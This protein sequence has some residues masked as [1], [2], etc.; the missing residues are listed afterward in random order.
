[1]ELLC[2]VGSLA[3]EHNIIPVGGLITGV[4]IEI[5]KLFIKKP[6]LHWSALLWFLPSCVA[7]LLITFTLVRSLVRWLVLTQRDL[8]HMLIFFL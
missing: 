3:D 6:E 2:R 8:V 5:L 7:D 1:M 4:K